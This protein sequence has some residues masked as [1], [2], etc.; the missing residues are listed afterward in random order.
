MSQGFGGGMP[1]GMEQV[2]MKRGRE[3]PGND[4]AAKVLA[5]GGVNMR[6][7]LGA[8]EAGT[9]IGPGGATIQDVRSQSGAHVQL[10]DALPGQT[11]RVLSLTGTMDQCHNAIR[12]SVM[13]L[14][15]SAPTPPGEKRVFKVL[16]ANEQIGSV[17]GKGG[18]KAREIRE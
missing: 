14:E 13:K 12:L 10:S 15:E 7:V 6:V 11:D 3:G 5:S 1:G 16:V 8:L 9:M 2:G 4:A 18:M 17:I